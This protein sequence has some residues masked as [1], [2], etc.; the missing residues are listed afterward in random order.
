M[1]YGGKVFSNETYINNAKGTADFII[2]NSID[3]DG[4]LLSTHINGGESYN[5]GFLEDYAFFYI[6][7]T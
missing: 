6:W 7:T 5:Y 1:A 2:A 4:N 3:K